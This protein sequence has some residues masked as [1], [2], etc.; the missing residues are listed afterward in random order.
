MG[1]WSKHDAASCEREWCGDVRWAFVQSNGEKATGTKLQ[2]ASASNVFLAIVE[3]QDI[4]LVD[5]RLT[6]QMQL[7]E[8]TTI[9]R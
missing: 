4:R 5:L 8:G 7:T 6:L 1:L 9:A 2:R 3:M